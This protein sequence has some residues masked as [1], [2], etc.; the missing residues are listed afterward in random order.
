VLRES[1]EGEQGERAGREKGREK[2]LI[3]VQLGG[4]EEGVRNTR[5]LLHTV[6]QHITSIIPNTTSYQTY[7]SYTLG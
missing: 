5:T 6:S 1:G 4:F 3:R 2:G 7:Q